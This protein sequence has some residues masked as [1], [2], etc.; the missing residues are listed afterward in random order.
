[1]R[2]IEKNR[3]AKR[4]N[5]IE[6]PEDITINMGDRE[7]IL[8]KGDRV[9][10]LENKEKANSIKEE[11]NSGIKIAYSLA[12]NPERIDK[13]YSSFKEFMEK[14]AIIS[15]DK[16]RRYHFRGMTYTNLQLLR[17][18]VKEYI[19]QHNA[20]AERDAVRFWTRKVDDVVKG[21]YGLTIKEKERIL[22]VTRDNF[23]EYSFREYRNVAFTIEDELGVDLESFDPTYTIITIKGL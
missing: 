18:D 19:E 13:V 17:S 14:E 5:V 10:I 7:I 11:T 23:L 22:V 21:L 1:M 12:K 3:K 15:H 8:E 20:E 2:K 16:G 6:L 9:R 4:E